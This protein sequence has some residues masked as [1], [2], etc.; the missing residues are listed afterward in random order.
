ME[1]LK[2]HF[3]FNRQQRNGILFLTL[4]ISVLLSVYYFVDFSEED[5][6]DTSSPEIISL[7]RELDSLR[8]IEIVNRKP[9]L[10]PF[11]PNFITDFKGYTLGMTHKEIDRLHQFRADD[12]WINSVQDFKKVT[13]V[14]DSLLIVISPYFKFPDWV[15]NPKSK[16]QNN[17]GFK[18]KLFAEKIDLNKATAKELQKVSGIGEVLSK[19]IIAYRVKLGGF[20]ADSQLNNVYG[21]NDQVVLRV[22]NEFTVKTSKEIIKMNINTISAS[23]I[24]TIPGISFDLAKTIWEYRILR[25]HINDFSELEKIEGMSQTK[26]TGIQLYLFIE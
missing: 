3:V 23:D 19:R 21:L 24:A 22:L 18:E 10:Y 5:V 13:Q 17:K 1:N 26:L 6:L 20:T 2:S 4:L 25:E 14:S 8:K 12:K 16:K 9:K 7:Q 11:N 15:T